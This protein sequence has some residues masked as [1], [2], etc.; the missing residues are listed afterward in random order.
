M[1][2]DCASV[3]P[4]AQQCAVMQ[5]LEPTAGEPWCVAICKPDPAPG[6]RE[7]SVTLPLDAKVRLE[8]HN[9]ELAVLGK[10]LADHCQDDL[11]IPARSARDIV[12]LSEK[13]TTLGAVIER[14]GLVVTPAAT[15]P[16]RTPR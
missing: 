5:I 13:D 16:S 15:S 7:D 4:N 1:G 9:T 14:A 3:C 8:V 6:L 11:L 12:E 10:F 2:C